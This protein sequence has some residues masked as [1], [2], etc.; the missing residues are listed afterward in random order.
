MCT[1][2]RSFPSLFLGSYNQWRQPG[3]SRWSWMHPYAPR[4]HSRTLFYFTDN[5]A[6]W[7]GEELSYLVVVCDHVGGL[8][9]GSLVI[10]SWLLKSFLWLGEVFFSFTFPVFKHGCSN[11]YSSPKWTVIQTISEV[12]CLVAGSELNGKTLKL[13][14]RSSP[15][16]YVFMN[17]CISIKCFKK[18][19][20]ILYISLGSDWLFQVLIYLSSGYHF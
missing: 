8:E 16:N 20:F 9:F 19:L 12:L 7:S 2:A 18:K 11:W 13:L 4:C 10:S 1:H 5:A 17:L 3:R 15:G 14:N 6:K